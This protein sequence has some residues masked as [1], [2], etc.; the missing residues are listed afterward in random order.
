MRDAVS[1]LTLRS[2]VRLDIKDERLSESPTL[3]LKV[4]LPVMDENFEA[5]IDA[6]EKLLSISNCLDDI[7]RYS[8]MAIKIGGALGEVSSQSSAKCRPEVSHRSCSRCPRASSRFW[9][10]VLM[11][12]TATS[13]RSAELTD[14]PGA[15]G[16]DEVS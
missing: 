9:S 10:L 14:Q 1:L 16:K 15:G 6:N 5:A 4:T 2:V 7:L 11:C 8:K 3:R 13:R 12:V